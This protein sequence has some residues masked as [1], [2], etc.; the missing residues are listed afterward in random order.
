MTSPLVRRVRGWLLRVAS[1]AGVGRGDA[2]IAEEL[3]AHRCFLADEY[4]QAGMSPDDA[5]RRAAAELGSVSSTAAA[6]RDQRGVPA[7]E[8]S[9]RDVRMA[10]RSFVRTPMLSL[11]IIAVLGLGIGL[12]TAIAAIFHAV[13]WMEL[14]VAAPQDVMRI[15]QRF[16][17]VVDHRVQGEVSRF[18]YPE[19]EMYRQS[20]RAFAAVTG[21]NH[22]NVTWHDDAETR[23]L[24]AALVAGDYFRVLPI[25]PARGRALTPADARE[26]VVVIA[27]RFWTQRLGAAEDAIG[28]RL[29]INGTA[30]TIVGVA[31][32]AFSG[33]EV[34]TVDV[35]LP[36]ETV[37]VVDGKRASSSRAT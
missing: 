17:G 23:P 14:P 8:D 35:W 3:E 31:P 37:S 22:A 21:V 27:H 30:Y 18:S 11:S 33:T 20:T 2:E 4:I 36:L 26:P 7:L 19:L 24:R 12:S 25:S 10:F 9:M 28:R 15:S 32:P 29:R 34:E 5:R 13:V 1:L 16:D 6:Y